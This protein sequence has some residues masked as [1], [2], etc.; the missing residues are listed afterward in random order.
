MT[1]CATEYSGYEHYQE[2]K[3]WDNAP[4]MLPSRGEVMFYEHYLSTIDLNGARVLEIGFGNGNFI[5]W[6]RQRGA[7]VYGT[8][9]Q[10]SAVEKALEYGVNV[11]PV[12]ISKSA[13]NMSEKFSV[14][15]A[16][17]VMEHLN[18]SQNI[19]LLKSA[20]AMLHTNGIL[21]LRFP[22]S[23]SPL[24]LTAQHGDVSHISTISIGIV[25][26]L[27][28]GLPFSVICAGAPYRPKTGNFRSRVIAHIQA[29]L[30]DCADH[31]IRMLYGDI[32]MY[33]NAIMVLRKNERPGVV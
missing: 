9:I 19:S 28:I 23:Q 20:A 8:E 31:V 16:I 2:L 29:V 13:Q 25:K 7:E 33:M 11:L 32:P 18:I 5:G 1:Q 17:D 15:V 30:R 6:A 24:S 21:M 4:F 14:I 26:Q 27:M 3:G 10:P 22:N 12:D